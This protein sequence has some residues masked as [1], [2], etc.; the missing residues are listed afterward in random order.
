VQ[1]PRALH[2]EGDNDDGLLLV[3][4]R[5]AWLWRA[6]AFTW[7]STAI[8]EFGRDARRRTRWTLNNI[9]PAEPVIGDGV[10]SFAERRGRIYGPAG[11]RP[12]SGIASGPL[13][14]DRTSYIE[15]ETDTTLTAFALSDESFGFTAVP[16]DTSTPLQFGD[17]GGQFEIG[18]GGNGAA[19]PPEEWEFAD[20]R[21][22]SD[23]VTF[24]R[25]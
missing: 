13:G 20:I 22:M 21:Q 9:E 25:L 6:A 4:A 16:V 8:V 12:D 14:D 11:V 19:S 23:W 10:V 17:A 7:H 3:L 24:R 18:F 1:R 2:A 5:C 15:Y